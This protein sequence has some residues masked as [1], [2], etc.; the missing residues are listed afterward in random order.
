MAW[1]HKNL[2]IPP[3]QNLLFRNQKD[4]GYHFNEFALIA[5]NLKFLQAFENRLNFGRIASNHSLCFSLLIY[6]AIKQSPVKLYWLP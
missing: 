2:A 4:M 3:Q 6:V 1:E 5:S